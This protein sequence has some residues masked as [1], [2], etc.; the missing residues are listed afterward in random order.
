MEQASIGIRELI[1]AFTLV[2][3]IITA[4]VFIRKDA[5]EQIRDHNH[6]EEAH[7]GLRKEIEKR[8]PIA[9]FKSWKKLH[10]VEVEQAKNEI[11]AAIQ[12][13]RESQ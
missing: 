10:G 6:S 7:A 12:A 8:L 3:L 4:W 11:I 9:E 13:E 2:G 5:R 1:G